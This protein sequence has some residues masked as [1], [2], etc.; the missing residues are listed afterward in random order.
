MNPSSPP[1]SFLQFLFIC[2][3]LALALYLF[4][5][6]IF[7]LYFFLFSFLFS[8]FYTLFIYSNFYSMNFPQI[9]NFHSGKPI[10]LSDFRKASR[11]GRLE[12]IQIRWVHCHH[13]MLLWPWWRP[14]RHPRPRLLRTKCPHR[15]T[16]SEYLFNPF[17]RLNWFKSLKRCFKCVE[18]GQN[19]IWVA[20]IKDAA[21]DLD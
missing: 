6:S 21:S 15:Q 7:L 5:A 8:F 10:S 18:I 17:P 3:F 9:M 20:S 12:W 2:G 4:I 16:K 19:C 11:F 13:P 1:C 14:R